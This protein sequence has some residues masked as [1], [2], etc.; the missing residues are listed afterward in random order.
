MASDIEKMEDNEWSFCSLWTEELELGSARALVNEKLAGDYFFNRASVAHYPVDAEEVGKIF[1]ERGMDCHLYFHSPPRALKVVDDMYV[2]RSAASGK[3]G[4]AT[5]RIERH[6]LPAWIDVFCGAFG[7]PEWK[8]EVERITNKN[9]EKL[10]LVLS[11]KD[12]EL[13]G[14]AALYAKNN[15]TGLY[16]LGT[17]KKFRG[18]GIAQ[19]ILGYAQARPR[20]FLQTLDSEGR[21]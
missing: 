3:S 16:C 15:F 17:I 7:V 4:S 8:S 5:S 9:F 11:Y 18:L 6:D 12:G 10:E 19:G 20:L 13:A 14:C 2:L 21:F 1:W